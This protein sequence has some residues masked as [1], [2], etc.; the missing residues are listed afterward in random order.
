MIKT[1]LW[2]NTLNPDDF[3]IF[4][5]INLMKGVEYQDKI[6]GHWIFL[7]MHPIQNLE[8]GYR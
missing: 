1:C 8:I 4:L 3:N 7:I 5:L 6:N 2:D